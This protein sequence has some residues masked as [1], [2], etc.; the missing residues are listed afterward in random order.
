[1]METL[2]N[3][4][5]EELVFSPPESG[6][7]LALTGLPGGGSKI[8][9]RSP[10][11]NHGAITGATWTRLPSG[12]WVL[13]YD[14]NDD[15]V[16]TGTS[17]QS[18][19]RDSFSIEFW[20]RPADGHPSLEE[21]PCGSRNASGEDQIFFSIQTGGSLFFNYRSNGNDVQPDTVSAVFFDGQET[22]HQIVATMSSGGYARLYF[23][24]VEKASASMSGVVM[25]DWTSVDNFYIGGR[26]SAGSLFHPTN[27]E[28]ALLR[29]HAFVL[30]T[31]EI[32]KHRDQEK[33]LFGVW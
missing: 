3:L 14:G 12:L 31:I 4:N 24:A 11:G 23:D 26:N 30:S 32:C 20:I 10:Y 28:I 1:M 21:I 2:I 25:A 6:C 22:W 29:I 19:F 15:K 7:A 9:D 8:Y 5:R 18:T 13:A 27:S 17:F 16:D 33:N